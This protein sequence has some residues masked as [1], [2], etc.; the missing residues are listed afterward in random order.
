MIKLSLMKVK[1]F[2]AFGIDTPP[3]L[4]TKPGVYDVQGLG[5]NYR[6]TDFQA[7]LGAGQMKRYEENVSRRRKNA[8]QLSNSLIDV[9]GI[10]FTSYTDSNSYFLFQIIIDDKINRDKVLCMLQDHDI[11][12]SIHYATPVPLMSY[13]KNKYDYKIGDFPNAEKYANQTISL[14]IHPKLSEIDMDYIAFSIKKI[15]RD[16][17]NES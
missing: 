11:G 3:E 16:V 2:K 12:V 6:M 1:K 17:T 4:R 14:P 10:S 15:I 9:N 8:K 5:Y 13:Y 7:A